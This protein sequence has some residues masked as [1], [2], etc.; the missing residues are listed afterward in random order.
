MTEE[1]KEEFAEWLELV[2]TAEEEQQADAE[3]ADA[4]ADAAAAEALD[5]GGGFDANDSEGERDLERQFRE[6]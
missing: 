4:A 2:R 5:E 1:Q 6:E 3:Q